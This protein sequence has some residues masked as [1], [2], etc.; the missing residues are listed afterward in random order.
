MSYS[1]PTETMRHT[2]EFT[3]E[4]G[5]LTRCPSFQDLSSDLIDG[6][7]E[8]AGKFAGGVFAPLNRVGDMQGCLLENGIVRSPSGFASAY[9]EFVEAG[10]N[11]VSGSPDFGGMGMPYVMQIAIQEMMTAA[12]M[13]FSLCPMLTQGAIEALTTHGTDQQ[14][15]LYLPNLISGEWSGTMNL[16]EPQA[17]SDVGALRTKAEPQ[18][19][20]T[21]R[22]KGQ[23]IYITWGE[24]EC[25]SNIIHLVLARLPGAPA[26]TKGISLFLVPK[27]LVKEDG[28]LGPRNDVKC[29][30]IEH[31][32]GIHASPTC[33][34]SFGDSD[35]CVG[36][37]IGEENRGMACMFTMMNNA[38]IAVGLQGVAIGDRAYQQALAYARDRVQSK[39]LTG[40]D[41]SARIIE[42]PD[43]RRMLLTIK[44][45]IEACR[46][47]VYR[48]AS[49]VDRAHHHPDADVGAASQGLADLLTPVAKAHSTDIGV[50][51][52]SMA[53]QVF[54]GMGYVEETGAAQH[55]RDSRIAPIYEGTN[56]IQ[57]LDLVGRKLNM[58]GGKHWKR[59]FSEMRQFTADL[60]S[61]GPLAALEPYLDDGVEALQTAAV[62]LFGSDEE[63]ILDTAAGATPFLRM[64][65]VIFGGYLLAV[66][67]K[68]AKALLEKGEGNPSFL[69]AKLNTAQ[70]YAEQI[71]P[72]G[73]ALLGP[74]TRG[75][76]TLYA[77]SEEQFA[78]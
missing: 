2:L 23:K 30:S 1:A 76:A 6:I 59:L 28:T 22:I 46:A 19:D 57:A 53:I 36:Y 70:F 49:E 73:T 16:T 10:W 55:L 43:V 60:P 34:M 61:S 12:N 77:I 20:G 67:A 11:C 5:E 58:D 75:A 72:Q 3:A 50:E 78:A 66:E 37:L 9:R 31:K 52:T 13:A 26:G 15:A 35:E 24:H 17:G 14:R 27:F 4:L 21:Y 44:A 48:T 65:G 63:E 47:L 40:S 68:A 64:F 74:I 8:Q 56:G 32:L 33:T 54:G 41:Q 71:M 29:V 25:S 18:P 39:T 42:H 7:L 62:N 45:N 51:M 69:E 38:R